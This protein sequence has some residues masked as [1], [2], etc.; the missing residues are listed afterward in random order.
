MKE[1]FS[2]ITT[3]KEELQYNDND[4]MNNHPELIFKT[5][6]K[7]KIEALQNDPIFILTGVSERHEAKIMDKFSNIYDSRFVITQI[8]H[9][10][11]LFHAVLFNKRDAEYGKRVLQH[12][13]QAK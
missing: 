9:K 7:K 11:E 12:L 3:I 6:L 5:S 4:L 2:S 8:E 13:F 1:C 10:G